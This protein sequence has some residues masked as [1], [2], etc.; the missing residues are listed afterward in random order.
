MQNDYI[1]LSINGISKVINTKEKNEKESLLR[2]KF[3]NFKNIKV[4][5]ESLI[6]EFANEVEE[7][8][9]EIENLNNKLS[10]EFHI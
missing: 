6:L 7:L 10:S 9:V 1:K 2:S 8:L 5:V 4:T 3:S